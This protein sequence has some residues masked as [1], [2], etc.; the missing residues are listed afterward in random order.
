MILRAAHEGVRD[1]H[2]SGLNTGP[3]LDWSR[4]DFESRS[5]AIRDTIVQSVESNAASGSTSAVR[6][7]EKQKVIFV[8]HGAPRSMGEAAGREAVGKPFTSDYKLVGSVLKAGYIGPIHLVGCPKNVTDL[9]ALNFLGVSDVTV[10]PGSFGVYAVDRVNM[11]QVCLLAQ[12]NDPGSTRNAV[13]RLFEWL[14]RSGELP[15]LIRRAASRRKILQ[16]IAQE[17]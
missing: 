15:P 12:C 6:I 10:V 11:V 7:L 1:F 17:I 16:V 13:A 3:A 5:Q 2:K 9:Q 8:C 4:M 14:S